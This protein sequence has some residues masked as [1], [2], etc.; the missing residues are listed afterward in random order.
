MA[1]L[2]LWAT[3]HTTPAAAW[4]A[5]GHR[6][7]GMIA[8][9]N[10]S[11]RAR[12]AVSHIL[13]GGSLADEATWM[14]QVRS[15]S[16]GRKMS[17]WHYV[18]LDLCNPNPRAACPDGE[19]APGRIEWAVKL[20]RD[21]VTSRSVD[22]ETKLTAVRV[23]THLVGD[24]HQPLHAAD[25]HDAGGNDVLITNRTCSS[26][27]ERPGS[28]CKLHTYWDSTLVKNL[29]RGASEQIRAA[30]WSTNF[31]QQPTKDSL[32]PWVWAKESHAIARQTA[33]SFTPMSCQQ[34]VPTTNLTTDYDRRAS[35]TVQQRIILAGRRLAM[36][37][38]SV[39][40]R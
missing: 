15:T 21:G 10:L 3:T 17:K 26:L 9:Q 24:V 12:I 5:E 37:L 6:I 20:L 28:S 18:N 8:D 22:D 35:V 16:F 32:D 19:C 1:L 2:T 29:T 38:N 4:G 33:Y 23:L 27:H 14:D 11:P 36:L 30:Q 34:R 13:H 39:Y 31:S 25:N 7:I 40:D